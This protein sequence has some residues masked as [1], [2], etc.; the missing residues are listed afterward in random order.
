MIFPLIIR[1]WSVV[2]LTH[3]A[4]ISRRLNT[5][6]LS[7]WHNKL[8]LFLRRPLLY[9]S[10]EAV[11]M[12]I[13]I[14]VFDEPRVT[15]VMSAGLDLNLVQFCP[16]ILLIRRR[17]HN[18][19]RFMINRAQV[20]PNR[21]STSI[22]ICP[23]IFSWYLSAS[24]SC[25]AHILTLRPNVKGSVFKSPLPWVIDDFEQLRVINYGA[26]HQI[27]IAAV[28]IAL[29]VMWRLLLN[30]RWCFSFVSAAVADSPYL[31]SLLKHRPCERLHTLVMQWNVRIWSL[32]FIIAVRLLHVRV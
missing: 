30:R 24:L 2:A 11:I 28:C 7:S 17:Y 20:T 12:R 25:P 1:A 16:P 6:R 22:Y 9:L 3:P 27:V 14:L 23:W 26:L 18:L 10:I 21:S 15:A 5:T 13:G 29:I 19:R 4:F 32:S 8:R 31:A